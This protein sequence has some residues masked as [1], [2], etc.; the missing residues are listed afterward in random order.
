MAPPPI[1]AAWKSSPSSTAFAPPPTGRDASSW[2]SAPGS[3]F[4]FASRIPTAWSGAPEED[5][6]EGK[7]P[8]PDAADIDGDEVEI[9]PLE[10]GET[11]EIEVEIEDG[12][13]VECWVERNRKHGDREGEARLLPPDCETECTARGEI[14]LQVEGDCVEVEV[15]VA[16]LQGPDVLEILLV[17][18][19]GSEVTL[20]TIDVGEDGRGHFVMEACAKGGELPFDVDDVDTKAGAQVLLVDAAGTVV[21]EGTLP[22]GGAQHDD[23]D[24]CHGA[25]KLL[26]PRAPRRPRPRPRRS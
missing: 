9:D 8:T 3:G 25:T 20:G 2:P 11:C 12:K 13:I 18:D 15:E 4:A 24:H 7:D 1:S 19:E 22:G 26:P 5:V 6:E 23:E 17:A 21:L 16:G 10:D 14:E